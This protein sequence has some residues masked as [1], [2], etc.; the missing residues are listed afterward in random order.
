MPDAETYHLRA[1][2]GLCVA[3]G[4]TEAVA[5]KK[6][7]AACAKRGNAK[8]NAQRAAR[9]RKKLCTRCARPSAGWHC[10]ACRARQAAWRRRHRERKIAA[11]ICGNCFRRRIA[12][13]AKA[14]CAQCL[15]AGR[16]RKA[17]AAK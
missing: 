3:C 13:P 10:A 2:L 7:C 6:R 12:P 15:R 14:H 17:A 1:R 8:G 4:K 5:G 16:E 11:G 9:R